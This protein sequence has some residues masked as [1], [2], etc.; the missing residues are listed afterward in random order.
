M[1]QTQIQIQRKPR[2]RPEPGSP[3]VNPEISRKWFE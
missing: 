1:A 3:T 2:P